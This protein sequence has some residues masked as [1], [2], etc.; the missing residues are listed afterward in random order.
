MTITIGILVLAL[1]QKF[2]LA[3]KTTF[4]AKIRNSFAILAL[5]IDVVVLVYSNIK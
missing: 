1:E 4:G 3:L 5:A 2:I